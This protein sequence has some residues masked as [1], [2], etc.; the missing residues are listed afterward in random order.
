MSVNELN[1]QLGEWLVRCEARLE[2]LL[3]RYPFSD[4]TP[5]E[6]VAAFVDADSDYFKDWYIDNSFARSSHRHVSLY[7][8]YKRKFVV[9]VYCDVNERD[10]VS[11][12]AEEFR[13]IGW[14][15]VV[16]RTYGDMNGRTL[17]KTFGCL[18]DIDFDLSPEFGTYIQLD[19]KGSIYRYA[20][21]AD[22]LA[23]T[24]NLHRRHLDESACF[25]CTE[26]HRYSVPKALFPDLSCIDMIVC[27]YCLEA[28][29]RSIR[30]RITSIIDKFLHYF[31]KV[32]NLIE[33]KNER[34]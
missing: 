9:I 19:K 3:R 28:Y 12:L 1:A 32:E 33:G 31:E 13:R 16:K 6:A 34:V 27:R 29:L 26:C 18:A 22:R 11:R 7:L 17:A 25:K 20:L 21:S 2:D 24:F 30:D 10:F 23:D 5:Q 15:Y 14:K 4:A 8:P